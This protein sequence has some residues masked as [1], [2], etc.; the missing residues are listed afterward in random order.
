[1]TLVGNL[2]TD[3][4]LFLLK[5]QVASVDNNKLY[6]IYNMK[7]YFSFNPLHLLLIFLSCDVVQ[8]NAPQI[9]QQDEKCETITVHGH[10]SHFGVSHHVLLDV[11][12]CGSAE[13]A[14]KGRQ[15]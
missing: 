5:L 7:S 14:A 15:N 9:A 10:I 13:E 3:Y 2:I 1:M 8:R 6:F 12:K 4:E 11:A